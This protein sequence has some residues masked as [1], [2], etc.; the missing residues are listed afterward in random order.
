MKDSIRQSASA[1]G[2]PTGLAQITLCAP[3]P[4]ALLAA[5]EHLRYWPYVKSFRTTSATTLRATV[6]IGEGLS[7]S[8]WSYYCRRSMEIMNLCL[9]QH[10]ARFIVCSGPLPAFE[11]Q[12][13][14][15]LFLRPDDLLLPFSDFIDA[16]DREEGGAV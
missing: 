4:Q 10:K 1:P 14:P 5:R 7:A 2:A 16:A 8:R 3:S 15:S 11:P 12:I 13:E 9:R 6:F